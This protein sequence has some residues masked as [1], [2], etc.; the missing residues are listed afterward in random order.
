MESTAE[1]RFGEGPLSRAAALIYTL[2]VIE[3]LFLAT[4]LPGLIGLVLLERDPGN[5]PLP[6]CACSRSAPRCPPR[7]TRCTA[8]AST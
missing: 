8:A 2:L 3:L 6:R 5:V 1:R 4:T 7:C